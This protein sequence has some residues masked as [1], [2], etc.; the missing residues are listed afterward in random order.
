M[1]APMDYDALFKA[2]PGMLWHLDTTTI[3]Q[4]T[5]PRWLAKMRH[6]HARVT[7]G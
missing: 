6:Q 4:R 1:A 5:E 2:D 3:V 7:E